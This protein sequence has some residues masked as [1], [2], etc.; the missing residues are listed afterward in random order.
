[1]T[2][3]ELFTRL[4]QFEDEAE[5]DE[6]LNALGYAL[7]NDNVWK[8]LGDMENNFSTVGNQHAEATGA[9]VEKL[10]NGIDALLMEECFK[11][12]IDPEGAPS[13]PHEWFRTEPLC[14]VL[15]RLHHRLRLPLTANASLL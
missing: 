4:L 6:L 9:F 10:I 7:N 1:M 3:Y 13:R 2:D 8:P 11:H 5:V 12:G 14:Q 15:P